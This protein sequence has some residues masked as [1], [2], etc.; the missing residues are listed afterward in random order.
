MSSRSM[1]ARVPT[2]ALRQ[3]AA[4]FEQLTREAAQE[5]GVVTPVALPQASRLV[6]QSI[7]PLETRFLHPVRRLAHE[8]GV[9]IERGAHADEHRRVEQRAHVR[10]P[11][12][13]LGHADPGPNDVCA[14]AVDLLDDGVLL[15]VAEYTVRRG[16]A[17]H[18]PDPWIAAAKVERELYE[19]ALIAPA[20]QVEAM[21]AARGS[22][23][24]ARH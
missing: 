7:G 5:A 10:H 13:L 6:R 21:P 2:S 4:V 16:V 11:L 15:L 12:L 8:S 14:R 18:D 17:A 22:L 3:P 1:R 20:V 24:R 19:R 9:E 23:A